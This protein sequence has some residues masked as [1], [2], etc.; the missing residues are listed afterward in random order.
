[1]SGKDRHYIGP[2][3]VP[4]FSTDT[5]ND[6]ATKTE[7]IYWHGD[8]SKPKN[9][10]DDL[11]WTTWDGS[12]HNVHNPYTYFGDEKCG[13]KE[14]CY[15]GSDAPGPMQDMANYVECADSAW[16]KACK[17]TGDGHGI[18][19]YYSSSWEFIRIAPAG[20]YRPVYGIMGSTYAATYRIFLHNKDDEWVYAGS[21]SDSQVIRPTGWSWEDIDSMLIGH[22]NP[23]SYGYIYYIGLLAKGEVKDGS[24]INVPYCTDGYNLIVDDYFRIV[25]DGK[26]CYWNVDCAIDGSGWAVLPP[27]PDTG[28]TGV[29][30]FGECDCSSGTCGNGY[31]EYEGFCYHNVK[32]ANGGWRYSSITKGSC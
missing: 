21:I 1:V 10:F 30:A 17:F 28:N 8:V 12:K 32:C 31:C 7:D 24:W 27:A 3:D 15:G 6:D 4:C 20:E 25:D 26:R 9:L 5:Q 11:S 19:P 14:D 16:G 29:G 13:D 23:K 18:V 22:W 2:G